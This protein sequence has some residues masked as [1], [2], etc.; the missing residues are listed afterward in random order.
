MDTQSVHRRRRQAKE[1]ARPHNRAAKAADSLQ[2]ITCRFLQLHRRTVAGRRRE[3]PQS[4]IRHFCGRH[5]QHLARTTVHIYKSLPG[6]RRTDQALTR[7]L[8]RKFK[9][10]APGDRVVPVDLQHIIFQYDLYQFFLGALCLDA[11]HTTAV[12]AQIKQPFAAAEEKFERMTALCLRL[13]SQ[14]RN[15]PSSSTTE[16]PQSAASISRRCL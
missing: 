11:K 9:A 1:P 13:E 7:P 6:S 4:N 10:R 15:K 16:P 12:Q 14:A 2:R 5:H 8:H 3:M